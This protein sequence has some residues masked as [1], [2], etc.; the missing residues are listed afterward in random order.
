MSPD[1]R[2]DLFPPVWNAEG[3]SASLPEVF[4]VPAFNIRKCFRGY[5]I[6]HGDLNSRKLRAIEECRKFIEAEARRQILNIAHRRDPDFWLPMWVAPRQGWG[7][8][9]QVREDIAE[10]TQDPRYAIWSRQQIVICHS[11]GDIAEANLWDMAAP[12]G[13]TGIP[14]DWFTGWRPLVVALPPISLAEKKFSRGWL[15]CNT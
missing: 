10:F 15:F 7:I 2:K 12:S 6:V 3:T 11:M 1:T 8:L 4:G 14:G 13:S 5:R 9:A